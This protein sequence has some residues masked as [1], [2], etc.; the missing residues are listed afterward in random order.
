V[1]R[2]VNVVVF[3]SRLMFLRILH[4]KKKAFNVFTHLWT[5]TSVDTAKRAIISKNVSNGN[6]DVKLKRWALW[7]QKKFIACLGVGTSNK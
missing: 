2:C 4:V 5:N 3:I 6:Y 1:P 7:C